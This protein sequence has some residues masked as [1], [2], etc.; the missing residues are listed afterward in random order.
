MVA[1]AVS[2]GLGCPSLRGADDAPNSLSDFRLR[3]DGSKYVITYKGKQEL[4]QVTGTVN[5]L[6]EGGFMTMARQQ[7][8]ATWKPGEEKVILGDDRAKPD[9]VQLECV[10]HLRLVTGET[11]SPRDYRPIPLRV[12]WEAK[13]GK[14]VL[15]V[16]RAV[17]LL[18][19]EFFGALRVGQQVTLKGS[20]QGY[21]ISTGP[22][23]QATHEVVW[24]TKTHVVL[25]DLGGETEISIP[26]HAMK[27]ITRLRERRK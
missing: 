15:F 13:T 6:C 23:L 9:Q 14:E 12:Q 4:H 16:G 19:E 1:L 10:G 21:Q 7:L 5:F 22:G 27:C 17:R 26:L 24:V 2:L 8:W 20:D 18:D 11:T 25:K 3:I